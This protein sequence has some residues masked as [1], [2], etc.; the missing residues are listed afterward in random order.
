MRVPPGWTIDGIAPAQG[1]DRCWHADRT[2]TC[3]VTDDP[4]APH[5]F[6]VTATGDPNGKPPPVLHT[7]FFEPFSRHEPQNYPLA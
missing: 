4:Q 2:A 5:D 1:S 7:Q 6:V 3:I